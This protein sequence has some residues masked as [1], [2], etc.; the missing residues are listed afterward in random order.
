MADQQSSQDRTEQPTERRKQES[1]KKGQVPRSKELNT[2]LSLLVGAVA[3]LVLGGTI[4]TEFITLFESSLSF[5]REVVYDKDM[6]PVRLVGLILSSILILTP[7]FAVLVVGAFAGP[8]LMGGW[9]FSVSAMAFK[10][11]KLN[12]GKGIK[13]VFSAKGLLELLKTLFKFVVLSATTIFLFNLLLDEILLLGFQ[14]P[15]EAFTDSVGLL[16]WSLL[17]I[18]SAMI[19][20]VVIDVPFEL[21]NHNKQL[22][23]TLQEVKDEMKESDGRPEVKARIRALQREAS[24]RRMMEAVPSADVIITNPTHF[25]VALKYDAKRGVAPVVLAKG[26]GLIAA[27]IRSMATDHDIAIFSAP[28]LARAL[29]S[30]AEIGEEIP[31]NLYLAVAK[32]LAYVFQLRTA[33]STDKPVAPEDIPIPAEY[34]NQFVEEDVNGE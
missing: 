28:P 34:R 22:K 32:V 15:Q 16:R 33:G 27:R 12:P 13:R 29:Y 3:L 20:I 2:T 7:F 1:R 10:I 23:M 8:L 31:K 9:S 26:R 14:P 21:W 19:F 18:S 6:I 11:D 24:Q 5:T 25:A 4:A 30:S 17:A